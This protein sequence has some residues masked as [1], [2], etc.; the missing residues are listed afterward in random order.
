MAAMIAGWTHEGDPWADPEVTWAVLWMDAV[1]FGAPYADNRMTKHRTTAAFAR[2]GNWPEAWLLRWR[3]EVGLR[4]FPHVFTARRSDPPD[5]CDVTMTPILGR[6]LAPRSP[7]T[8][9]PGIRP[10]RPAPEA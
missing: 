10:A 3:R 4:P 6:I 7:P 1:A 8:Q 2:K 9:S 5:P